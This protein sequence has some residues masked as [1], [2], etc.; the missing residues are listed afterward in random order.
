MGLPWEPKNRKWGVM[1]LESLNCPR[2]RWA[3]VLILAVVVSPAHGQS[4]I[5]SRPKLPSVTIVYEALNASNALIWLASDEGLYEKYGLNVFAVHGRGATAVQALVS[6]SSE[7]GGFSGSSAINANL[8]GS[9]IV[10]VAARPNF[11]VMSIWV[12]RDSPIKSLH[13]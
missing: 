11:V 6:G 8:K 4:Q 5:F 9:D 2:A 10:I 1:A 12:R 3:Y 13:A 7:F